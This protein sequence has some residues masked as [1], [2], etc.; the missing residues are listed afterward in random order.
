M[1]RFLAVA[2]AVAA[3]AAAAPARADPPRHDRGYDSVRRDDDGY[4]NRGQDYG[5][6]YGHDRYESRISREDIDR[7]QMRIDMSYRT[8][9]LNRFEARRLSWMVAD[10]RQRAR[11]YWSDG[12]SWRERRDLEARYDYVRSELHRELFEVR[13]DY[14][15]RGDRWRG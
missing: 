9:V 1:K 7:L 3:L 11:Y 13:D 6:G 8:G 2:A 12:M 10:L 15:G 14:R 4:Y 5:R